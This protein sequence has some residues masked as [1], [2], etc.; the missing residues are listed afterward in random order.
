MISFLQ[1]KGSWDTTLMQ[2][3]TSNH[4]IFYISV[5]SNYLYRDDV[6]ISPKHTRNQK[7]RNAAI[8]C[9]PLVLWWH[10]GPKPKTWTAALKVF[11]SNQ[12]KDKECQTVCFTSL[13]KIS[14]SCQ[15]WS[16]GVGVS[17][18]GED[19][20]VY[21][22]RPHKEATLS[23]R[24]SVIHTIRIV[25]LLWQSSREG[26]ILMCWLWK[27]MLCWNFLSEQRSQVG[28]LGP[29]ICMDEAENNGPDCSCWEIHCTQHCW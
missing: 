23:Q 16:S 18:A 8:F 5:I 28:F 2:Y 22:S 4:F 9:Y 13:S 12:Y 29:K 24:H 20:A 3:K 19:N 10:Q 26:E 21:D 25:F 6:I 27:K 14:C 7:L 17:S 11:F 15:K 1:G